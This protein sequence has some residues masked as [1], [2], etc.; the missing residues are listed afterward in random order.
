MDLLIIAPNDFESIEKKSVL[1]QYENY[2]EGGYF[3][4]II[5]F[6]PFTK[7]DLTRKIDENKF[8]Y[9][10]GWKS[11]FHFLNNYKV[12]KFIGTI[13]VLFKI[14]FVFPFVI[15][16][17]NIKIIRATDPYLNGLIGLY[18]SKLF[19][20]PLA[21]SV[22]SDYSLCNDAGG[23]TFKLFGSRKLAEKLEYFVYKRCDAILPISQY[24]INR[25]KFFYP[26]LKS[27]KF[28]K[29]PHGI[30]TE[31]FDNL[32]YLDIYDKFNISRDVKLICYVARL[33]KEKNCLDI[34]F[35]VEKLSE[36]IQSFVVLIVGD[37]VERDSI[38]KMIIGKNLNQYVKF[39]GFQD[40]KVV[41]NAR[42]LADVNICLLDGYSLIEAGLS[43]KPVVAYDVEWHSDLIINE[44]NGFLVNIHDTETFSEQI[45]NLLT[46]KDLANK[47]GREL[48]N[49]TIQNHKIE[50]TQIIKQNIY[51][52]IIEEYKC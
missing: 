32:E 51:T 34:P 22:H 3:D 28:Y 25:I 35:I 19:K 47:F 18:Y 31:E 9:Q 42:K 20:I 24:L 15:K 41:F 37:G 45:C 43:Q 50:N 5:S 26:Y 36:K 44:H 29:F 33:S 1:Y 52:K 14:L 27:D 10:Y 7:I 30:I 46:K 8:F 49:F 23:L 40:K 6:F 39:V 13:I 2:R 12:M 48:R 11:K 17:Y 4:N 21:I 16:K 38:Q